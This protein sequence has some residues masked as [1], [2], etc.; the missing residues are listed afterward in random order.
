MLY[1]LL[2]KREGKGVKRI[3]GG[4]SDGVSS[5]SSLLRDPLQSSFVRENEQT[6]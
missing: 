3:Y 6:L 5:V 2:R 4:Q 1:F